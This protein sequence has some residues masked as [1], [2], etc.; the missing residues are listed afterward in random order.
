MIILSRH[1]NKRIYVLLLL[2]VVMLVGMYVVSFKKLTTSSQAAN[3]A[4]DK[5][6]STFSD[7][8]AYCHFGFKTC[9]IGYKITQV[10]CG[11]YMG[12][13]CKT[14]I[15]VSTPT[16]A[17]IIVPISPGTVDTN[18]GFTHKNCKNL[19]PEE[20]CAQVPYGR[21]HIY[22]CKPLDYG[23]LPTPRPT[24]GTITA[25]GVCPP[26][27]KNADGSKTC[28]T[29]GYRWGPDQ[30]GAKTCYA[31]CGNL[32]STYCGNA[33]LLN[34]N[35]TPCCEEALSKPFLFSK[36][37]CDK[38]NPTDIESTLGAST[39]KQICPAQFPN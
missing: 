25:N 5:C 17:P 38:L 12:L 7:P 24:A 34:N 6:I 28:Q 33:K 20:K 11:F 21:S 35:V 15:A 30:N 16:L 18:C 22:L 23:V 10:S 26:P 27:I 14:D 3:S 37:C 2:I 32:Y 29:Q 1:T 13:C 39:A 19:T 9:K 31:I 36:V 4:N 8:S